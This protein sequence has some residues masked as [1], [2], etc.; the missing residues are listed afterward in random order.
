MHKVLAFDGVDSD[1]LTSLS[2]DAVHSG[3]CTL[4]N[5]DLIPNL[6]QGVVVT[7]AIP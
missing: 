6:T 3:P 7:A 5:P 4:L 1:L 2:I